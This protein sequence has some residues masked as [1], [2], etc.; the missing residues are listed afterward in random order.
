MKTVSVIMFFLMVW[1]TN[2]QPRINVWSG[3][4]V[5]LSG[6]GD[7]Q[8]AAEHGRILASGNGEVKLNLPPLNDGTSLDADLT[9]D[10]KTRKIRIWSPKPL[11]GIYAEI[12]D[13]SPKITKQLQQYGFPTA[14]K[15]P[16]EIRFCRNFSPH[17]DGRISL[18]FPDKWGFPLA[19]GLD[20]EKISLCNAKIPGKLSVLL[21]KREQTADIVGSGSY[22]ELVKGKSR[23]YVFS[24]EFNFDEIEN[25]LLIKQLIKENSK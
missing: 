17:S 18:V 23:I 7:W 12:I 16:P 1:S 21:D 10:G 22:I 4:E 19:L 6:N 5:V 2:A 11:V 13:L 15:K 14:I 3:R 25:V 8:I 9:L 20:W 24:P